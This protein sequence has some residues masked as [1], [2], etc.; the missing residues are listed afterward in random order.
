[1]SID[2]LLDLERDVENGR[3]VFACPGMGSKQWVFSKK[4][5]EPLRNI[6]QRAANTSRISVEIV[7]LVSRHNVVAN[8][9]LVPT[10]IREVGPRGEAEI[11]WAIVESKDAAENCRDIIHD[12]PYFAVEIEEVFSPVHSD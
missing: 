11:K 9:M 5:I 4:G 1:M 12:S 2:F 8:R 6:A 10:H 7:R 3:E